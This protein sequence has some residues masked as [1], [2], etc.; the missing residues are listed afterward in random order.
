MVELAHFATASPS[1]H[2]FSEGSRE[3]SVKMLRSFRSL[4]HGENVDAMPLIVEFAPQILSR[5]HIRLSD[6]ARWKP[7]II[8]SFETWKRLS[9]LRMNVLH[10][11]GALKR[12]KGS[13]RRLSLFT[14][15]CFPRTYR[16]A[17]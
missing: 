13:V 4:F 12:K 10:A 6:Q 3:F 7:S 1:I 2:W 16:C 5:W 15:A 11:T 8:S 14:T 17:L 9:A